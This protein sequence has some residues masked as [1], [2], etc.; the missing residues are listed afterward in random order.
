MIEISVQ[1]IR[2]Q[3]EKCFFLL[4]ES[5]SRSFELL[6][7]DNFIL[8]IAVEGGEESARMFKTKYFQMYSVFSKNN[9]NNNNNNNKIK[10]LQKYFQLFHIGLV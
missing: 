8:E 2:F 9:N 1:K 4:K 10:D 5:F 7:Y 3:A 6:D